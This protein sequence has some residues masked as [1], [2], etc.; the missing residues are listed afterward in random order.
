MTRFGVLAGSG[1]NLHFALAGCKTAEDYTASRLRSGGLQRGLGGRS[2]P[3]SRL[4]MRSIATLADAP[5]P[6]APGSPLASAR[7]RR[8]ALRS[9][10]RCSTRCRS[11]K[12]CSSSAPPPA[13]SRAPPPPGCLSHRLVQRGRGL[14]AVFGDLP[15]QPGQHFA[16]H[17]A[18]LVQQARG[19]RRPAAPTSRCGAAADAVPDRPRAIG[20]AARG[21]A[22]RR[23]V[24]GPPARAAGRRALAP[25]SRAPACPTA[26]PDRPSPCCAWRA[27]SGNNCRRRAPS[28]RADHKGLACASMRARPSAVLMSA[29]R[30]RHA[31]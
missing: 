1:G 20:S 8:Q 14:H 25:L 16:V 18:Q 10:P 3:S 13:A 2:R 6:S 28:G 21:S 26:R 24:G 31:P 12:P 27:S 29:A 22:A 19:P 17:A 4:A 30:R 5:A 7:H 23:A 9:T 11:S 15:F